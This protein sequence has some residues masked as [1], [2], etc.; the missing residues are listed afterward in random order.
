MA[1]GEISQ[2]KNTRQPKTS[3][4]QLAQTACNPGLLFVTQILKIDST[5][6]HHDP[7]M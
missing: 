2:G 7:G 5:E 1:A 3:P 4:V 6:P